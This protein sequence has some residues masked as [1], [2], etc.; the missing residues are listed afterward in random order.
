MTAGEKQEMRSTRWGQ[1]DALH[2]QDGV[3]EKEDRLYRASRSFKNE[4]RR[5]S[6]PRRQVM[7]T[8]Y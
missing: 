8:V 1:Q 5:G 2:Q 7:M 3:Q 6:D 4:A